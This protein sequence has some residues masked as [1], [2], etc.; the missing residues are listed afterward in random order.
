MHYLQLM[1]EIQQAQVLLD[2]CVFASAP[3]G[4]AADT[5]SEY[6]GGAGRR[7][8]VGNPP[9]RP[10]FGCFVSILSPSSICAR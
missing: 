6:S 3:T 1:S 5:E 7:I 2:T 4:P 8:L 10:P 9:A